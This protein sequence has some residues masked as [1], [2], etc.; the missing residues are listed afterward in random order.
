VRDPFVIAGPGINDGGAVR[1][2]YAHAIDVLPT[3][4]DLCAIG[5]PADVAGIAQ[6]S[7]DG[8]SLRP[9]LDDAK[10]DDVRMRQYY[11]CWGSRAMY[12]D[13]WK[14]VTNHVNQLTAAE[15]DAIAGGCR[16]VAAVTAPLARDAYGV[17]CEQG[18]WISGWAW[19]LD[20]GQLRWCIAGKHGVR[21][22]AARVPADV[23]LL[24]ADGAIVDGH[25]EVALHA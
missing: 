14:A 24:G 8:V 16:M 11:E 20:Q 2:Q 25:V 17:L 9:V 6:M 12:A 3:L 19:Y 15:R 21:E 5:L 23:T 4:L 10:A 7:Y 13:G 22:V 18:D 1:A